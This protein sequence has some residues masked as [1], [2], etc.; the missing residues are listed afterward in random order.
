[1]AG[2][3]WNLMRFDN[4]RKCRQ[5]GDVLVSLLRGLMIRSARITSIFFLPSFS[6]TSGHIK[7]NFA[8]LY[9]HSIK[10]FNMGSLSTFDVSDVK[11]LGFTVTD[12]RFPTSLDGVGSDAMHVGTNGSHPYIR[13]E[14]NHPD[15]VGEGI[16]SR[17]KISL[18]LPNLI[19]YRFVGFQQWTWQRARL[20]GS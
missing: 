7:P 12:L 2:S 3:N 18:D 9:S 11:V 15:L 8:S 13:L 5:S 14:T 19:K 10:V 16:V 1:M 17:S 4:Y 6:I 20:H